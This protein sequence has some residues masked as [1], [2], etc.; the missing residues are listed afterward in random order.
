MARRMDLF[1]FFGS[2]YSYLAVMRAE[3]LAARAGVE[4]HW[5]PFNVR[6]IMIEQDN[7]PRRNPVKMQYLWR[8]I[9]RRARR[10]GVPFNGRPPFPVDAEFLAN[11]VGVVAAAEGWCPAYARATFTAWFRD[12]Q[13]PGDRAHLEVQLRELGKDAGAV[14]ARAES[15]EV[16]K[17]FDAQTDAARKLGIFGAPT[18]VVGEEL[19]WGDDRLEDALDCARGATER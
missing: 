15:K 4:L 12:H 11:R 10:Y 17:A 1:F 5:R 14:I 3:A 19:F 16:R 2:L 9:E 6:A 8:D 7:I 18:F 13:A